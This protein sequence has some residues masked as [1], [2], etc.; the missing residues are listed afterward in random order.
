MKM[1]KFDENILPFL[2]RSSIKYQDAGVIKSMSVDYFRKNFKEVAATELQNI[3]QYSFYYQSIQS[4]DFLLH[5][6]VSATA[7]IAATAM[8]FDE[9]EKKRDALDDL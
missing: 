8:R 9:F 3:G 6:R 2:S 4:P 5:F 1:N 7:G